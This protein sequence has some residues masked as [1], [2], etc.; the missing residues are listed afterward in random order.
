MI[1][2]IS[3]TN[4]NGS[5]TLKVAKVYEN[6]L[7]ELGETVKFCDLC[8]M[9]LDMLNNDMY[10]NPSEAFAKF[11]DELIIQA[12]KF[13]IVVPEYNGSFPGIFKLMIDACP[14][15]P[16][17]HG[18]KAMLTGVSAGRAGNLRGLDGLTNMMNYIKM[19]IL[20]NKLPISGIGDLLDE[21]GNFNHTDTIEL[22][23]TQVNQFLKF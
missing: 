4:R 10:G 2:I 7:N 8:E 16:A 17:F 23:K 1:T 5:N 9:P 3:G 12:K 22:M 18:K 14:V 15:Q 13:V 6:Y 11:Q 19:D 21:N 20:Q